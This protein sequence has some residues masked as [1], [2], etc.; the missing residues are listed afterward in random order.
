MDRKYDI[1]MVSHFVPVALLNS[2]KTFIAWNSLSDE[3][4]SWSIESDHVRDRCT[5]APGK[6]HDNWR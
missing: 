4:E 1:F 3:W 2:K 5:V 6:T